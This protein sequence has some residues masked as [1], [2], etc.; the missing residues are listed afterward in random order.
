MCKVA[1]TCNRAVPGKFS[2]QTRT[3]GGVGAKIEK[4]EPPLKKGSFSRKIA[5]PKKALVET[6]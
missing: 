1:H 5:E 3:S 4:S 6:H 2:G